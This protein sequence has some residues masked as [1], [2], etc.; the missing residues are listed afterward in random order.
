MI[1]AVNTRLRKEEQPAG[2]E[3]FM[4]GLLDQLTKKFPE[5]Q[6]LY[7]TDRPFDTNHSLPKNVLPV[8]T[9]PETKN[10]LRLLYWFNYKIPAILR[11]HK[12]DVF[13]SMEGICSL[14]TKLPQLL[15]ISDLSLLKH[16]SKK[17]TAR[18]Y[19]KNMAEF[20]KKAKSI[21]T[22]SGHY[23]T[24]LTHEFRIKQENIEIIHPGIDAVF[25]PLDWEEQEI[26]REKYAAGKAYFLFSGKVDQR[27]NIINLLK[28]FSFFKRRQKS[29]MLLII[30]GKA[31]EFFKKELKT[32]K[33][34][35]EV[36][37]LENLSKEELA[38]VTAAAY[39]MVY[40]VLYDSLGLPV[41]QAMRSGVP[42]IVSN[43]V[44][45]S[46][47][48]GNAALCTDPANVSDIAEN[49]MLVFKDEQ[50]VATLVEAG[51]TL[52]QQ[53]NWDRSA[54]QLMKCILKAAD[55]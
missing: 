17:N 55:E 12:A 48:C 4:F 11:K 16:L 18:S 44:T 30:A 41:L 24:V 38:K 50:K 47:I 15:L 9:G 25:K 20:L 26:T 28:A 40:P 52:L 34:R 1:I 39:A 42:V 10:K 29:N 51:K 54:D 43:S 46:F 36:I 23:Q 8:V 45:L 33:Y 2:Y 5:H 22:V 27:S 13:V 19:R 49:M 53:Y 7:I 32:Y 35:N 31:D 6:F 21:A 37:L 3:E 14:R